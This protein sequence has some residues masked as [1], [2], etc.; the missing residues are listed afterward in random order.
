MFN[1]VE[2]VYMGSQK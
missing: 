1:K 2:V